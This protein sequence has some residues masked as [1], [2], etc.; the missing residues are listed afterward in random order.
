MAPLKRCPFCKEWFNSTDEMVLR[1][2]KKYHGEE[3]RP[4]IA[5]AT[6]AVAAVMTYLPFLQVDI[7]S[8]VDK[9]ILDVSKVGAQ[10]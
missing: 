3:L 2:V 6:A 9:A 4:A 5:A 10:I 8:T 7:S 1:H